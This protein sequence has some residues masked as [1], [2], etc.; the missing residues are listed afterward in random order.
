VTAVT[1]DAYL[2]DLLADI[3][4]ESG[5]ETHAR[6]HMLATALA[7]LGH[8]EADRHAAAIEAHAY[9]V[10]QSNHQSAADRLLSGEV[11]VAAHLAACALGQVA[12]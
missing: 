11:D 3:A 10:R 2:R 12:A 7:P 5:V 6:H 8:R 4:T 1:A 9:W